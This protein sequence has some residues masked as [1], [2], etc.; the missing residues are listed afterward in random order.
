MNKKGFTFIELLGAIVIMIIMAVIV[1]V[2]FSKMQTKREN[3]RLEEFKNR[4][5]D[6][7]CVYIDLSS[8]EHLKNNNT[9]CPKT[10]E[11]TIDYCTI[12]FIDLVNDGLVSE[13]LVNPKTGNKAIT[14]NITV[15]ITWSGNS[16]KKCTIQGV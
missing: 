2:N 11:G 9:V 13:N 3:K 6:S 8:N 5:Q 7:A 14:E 12:K 10:S 15:K 16:V 4:V 1:T